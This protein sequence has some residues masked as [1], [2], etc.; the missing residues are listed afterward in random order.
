MSAHRRRQLD[1]DTAE[2]LLRGAAPDRRAGKD[3][4]ID[5]LAA[6]APPS[7]TLAT[8]QVL[9]GEDEA[10]TAFREARF[11][12][13]TAPPTRS[14]VKV[15][16]AT[17]LTW[18]ALAAAGL[19][20]SAIGGAAIVGGGELDPAP[21]PSHD[22]PAATREPDKSSSSRGV[23][24][25]PAETPAP[26]APAAA[27]VPG[28]AQ[29]NEV[30]SPPGVTPG[31]GVAPESRSVS[32]SAA[33]SRAETPAA[34][35]SSAPTPSPS[36]EGLCLAYRAQDGQLTD[37]T[38]FDTLVAAAGGPDQVPKYCDRLLGPDTNVAESAT[39][40]GTPTEPT[41][42][43]STNPAGESSK[44]PAPSRD[45]AKSLPTP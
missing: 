15:A 11:S 4:L 16:M 31:F 22:A 8:E 44:E 12:R 35:A 27:A 39:P 17:L 21:G 30:P 29:P 41:T 26:D 24:T 25:P 10:V 43:G 34:S 2:R 36:L 14:V 3:P 18:K 9:P 23:T 37:S 42:G 28:T 45:K 19:T 32:P 38:A 20:A 7:N 5:L 6:V 40:T 1:R 33:A 13:V